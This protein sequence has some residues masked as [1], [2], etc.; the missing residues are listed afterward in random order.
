MKTA[1]AAALLSL[2]L[3]AQA[4]Y[5]LIDAGPA[6]WLEGHKVEQVSVELFNGDPAIP[7]ELARSRQPFDFENLKAVNGQIVAMTTSEIAARDAAEAQAAAEAAA[8]ANLYADPQ[9][10]IFVPRYSGDVTNVVGLSQLLVDDATDELVALDETGSPEH[11]IQQKREQNAARKAEKDALKAK[12]VGA[13]NDKEK[14]AA[15]MEAV[16]GIK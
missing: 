12:A 6:A 3:S 16:F 11:T 2:C 15:L 4:F 10:A 8:Q 13:K 9:P 14:Q 7:G 1:F 5:V